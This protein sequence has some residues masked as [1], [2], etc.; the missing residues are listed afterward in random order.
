MIQSDNVWMISYSPV[1]SNELYIHKNVIINKQ[2]NIKIKNTNLT[3]E[4]HTE[5]Q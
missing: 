3:K 1:I 4:K 5:L 2:I